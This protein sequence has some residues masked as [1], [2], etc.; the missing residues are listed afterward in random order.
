MM[1]LTLLTPA[2]PMLFQ[3]QEF[4]ATSPFYYFADHEPELAKLV[5]E[6]RNEFLSQFPSLCDSA[7]LEKLPKP[8]DVQTFQRC[9]LN[10]QERETNQAALQLTRDLLKLRRETPAFQKQDRSHV[11]GAVL[12]EK[13]FVIRFLE[14]NEGDRLLIVN[15]GPDLHLQT[16]PE[17]LLAPPIDHCWRI[18]FSTES[19]Q[20]G[21]SGVSEV[22][23]LQEGWR[24]PAESAVVLR[25][26]IETETPIPRPK[27]SKKRGG[28]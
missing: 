28:N 23:T 4:A 24:I 13:A 6:G 15:L 18:E 20:Y 1:T 2:T 26:E 5:R 25:P 11:D 19:V 22:E 17:P 10:W 3:G 14:D 16:C 7:I 21:G 12:S 8:E 27:Q 9:Q